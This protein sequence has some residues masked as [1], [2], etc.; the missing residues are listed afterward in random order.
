MGVRVALGAE[1]RDVISLI[2]REGLWIVLPGVAIGE[3]SGD[4]LEETGRQRLAEL[5]RVVALIEAQQG[6]VDMR[7]LAPRRREGD[8][9]R[10]DIAVATCQG[11]ENLADHLPLPTDI[12]MPPPAIKG[13]T[14]GQV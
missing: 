4:L 7:A 5:R 14:T 1:S 13:K 10:R 11:N 8:R 3:N 2:V 12:P 9:E 6:G